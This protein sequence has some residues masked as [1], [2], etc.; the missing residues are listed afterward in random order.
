M[1]GVVVGLGKDR[2]GKRFTVFDDEEEKVKTSYCLSTRKEK[3]MRISLC[4]SMQRQERGRKKERKSFFF[5][6]DAVVCLHMCRLHRQAD[7]HDLISSIIFLPFFFF[8]R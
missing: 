8:V 7:I 3:L 1:R 2:S 4:L 5:P 6:L